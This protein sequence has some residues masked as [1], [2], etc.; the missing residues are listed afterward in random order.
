MNESIAVWEKRL[1]AYHLPRWDELP[2]MEL[3]MDQV[4]GQLDKYL[5][6]LCTPDCTHFITASM[7]N[8]YVKLHL[9]PAPIKKRYNRTHLAYLVIVC[10]LKQVLSIPEIKQLLELQM[11][12][13]CVQDAY[14]AFCSA[15][16]HAFADICT[17]ALAQSAA[18][19]A[20]TLAVQLAVQ[21]AACKSLTQKIFCKPDEV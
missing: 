4:T 11:Q 20:T 1:A 18:L 16:E 8:N 3:Y 12:N 6:V 10:L 2:D 9:V 7:I 15:Q 5:T 14:D 13:T 17:R 19:D 21:A